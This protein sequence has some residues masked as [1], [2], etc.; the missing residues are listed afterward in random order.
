MTHLEQLL[1]TN[2]RC[3]PKELVLKYSRPREL[4]TRV[5][6]FDAIQSAK[7]KDFDLVI[8]DTAG[9]LHTQENLMEELKKMKRVMGKHIER[10]PYETLIVLDSNSGQNALIQTEKFNEALGLS[11][12]VLTK[13]DGSAKG[14]VAVGLASQF[15]LPIKMIGVGEGME[16]LRPF[17]ANEFV[18]SII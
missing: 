11:G 15:Q 13:L 7:S 3:G 12:A 5:P 8:I 2:S 10:A 16:D 9:R 14:G 6:C 1:E 4:A 17:D 18:D